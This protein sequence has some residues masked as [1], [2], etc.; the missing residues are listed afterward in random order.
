M[1]SQLSI[2]L[3]L[4]S[5]LEVGQSLTFRF[6]RDGFLL[7]GFMLRL[8]DKF[9]AYANS[10]PHWDIDLDLGD[11]RFYDPQRSRIYCK[12]HGATFRPEDGVCDAGPCKGLGLE[13]FSVAL[14]ESGPVV[15]IPDADP[16]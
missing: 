12:N 9:V 6:H 3:P 1:G 11:E 8:E 7:Q 16:P 13:Q 14:S 5:A 10:C 15:E 4:A 2:A